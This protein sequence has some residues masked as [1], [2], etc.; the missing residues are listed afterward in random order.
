[1]ETPE[2][3]AVERKVIS[4]LAES[5]NKGQTRIRVREIDSATNLTTVDVDSALDRLVSLRA[6]EFAEGTSEESILAK[7]LILIYNRDLRD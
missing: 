4:F 1:M 7:Q 6:L 5:L 3:N 2:F